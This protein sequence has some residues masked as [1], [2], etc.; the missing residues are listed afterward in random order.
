MRRTIRS[1]QAFSLCVLS[2]T[3]ASRVQA[4]DSSASYPNKPV[5]LIAPQA[6]GGG[7]DLVGRII[8]DQLRLA[9]GQ[10]FLLDNEAGAGGAIAAKMTS[11][12]APDGTP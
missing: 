7:V 9:M 11:R 12:A 8:V 2:L 3:L 6:P 4:Q 5:K 1:V 10:P